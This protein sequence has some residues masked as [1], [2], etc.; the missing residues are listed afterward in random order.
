MW[1]RRRSRPEPPETSDDQNPLASKENAEV[2]GTAYGVSGDVLTGLAA[3]QV[4][5]EEKR[6]NGG[7]LGPAGGP[8]KGAGRPWLS[9]TG[10]R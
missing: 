1:F 6:R 5:A 10:R 9:R 8:P 2:F 7:S 4:T 3:L